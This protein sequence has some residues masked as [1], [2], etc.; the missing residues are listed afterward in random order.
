MKTLN[1][2][3]EECRR[4]GQPT[5]Y[6]GKRGEWYVVIA[7]SRDARLLEESNFRS[8]LKAL[9]GESTYVVIERF[10]HWAVGWIDYILVKPTSK[11]TVKRARELLEKLEQYPVVDESDY[12]EL[13]SEATWN[14]LREALGYLI[15]EFKGNDRVAGL[16][17][18]WLSDNLPN[19]LESTDDNGGY[20]SDSDL[21][22]ALFALAPNDREI[23]TALTDNDYEDVPPLARLDYAGQ[24]PMFDGKLPTMSDALA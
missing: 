24:L 6:F 11:A 5:A 12:S 16:V 8:T 18:R 23:H 2:S 9:G 21:L 17:D 19:A 14:N 4:A 15:G 7:K 1:Q 20:P 10:H 3:A 13:E 22:E